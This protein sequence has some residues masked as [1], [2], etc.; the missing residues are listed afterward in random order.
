MEIGF[1]S[2]VAPPHQHVSDVDR[3][4]ALHRVDSCPLIPRCELRAG[5]APWEPGE[6]NG[7]VPAQSAGAEAGEAGDRN[8]DHVCS[9]ASQ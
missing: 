4:G 9:S 2:V 8:L 3:Q 5:L 6:K 1:E 7:G